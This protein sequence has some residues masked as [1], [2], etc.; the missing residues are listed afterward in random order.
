M[1]DL[2]VGQAELLIVLPEVL[3]VSCLLLQLNAETSTTQIS[4]GPSQTGSAPKTALVIAATV[5]RPGA[6]GIVMCHISHSYPDGAS[7]YFT[8]IFPRTLNGRNVVVRFKRNEAA[9]TIYLFGKPV[10]V[11]A[12]VD[13][14]DSSLE[15]LG[16]LIVGRNSLAPRQ[17][18]SQAST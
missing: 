9:T 18:H 13:A 1:N 2:R 3:R 4:P 17:E 12:Q 8:Y 5:P 15:H 14:F 16:I 6:K 11:S 7:L 10:G